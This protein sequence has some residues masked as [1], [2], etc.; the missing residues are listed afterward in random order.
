MLVL[1][2]AMAAIGF[3]LLVTALTTGSVL[4]A[5]GC[6]VVC[7]IGAVLLLV[8]ALSMRRPENDAPPPPGRHAK[9]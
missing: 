6:I 7:V 4:W 3:A 9:R 2:L 5:W 8:S 1:T